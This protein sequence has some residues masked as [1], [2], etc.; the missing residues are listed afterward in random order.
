MVVRAR[1][2][3]SRGWIK[4]ALLACGFAA[5]ALAVVGVVVGVPSRSSSKPPPTVTGCHRDSVAPR[6]A[7][8]LSFDAEPAYCEWKSIQPGSRC[9]DG[10]ISGASKAPSAAFVR[11]DSPGNVRHGKYS[12]R[13]VLNPG[14]HT[15]YSCQNESVDAIK[16]IGEGEGTESWWGWS[17]KLPVGWRGTTSFGML[18]QFTVDH[19]LWPSYGM[20]NF[21]AGLSNSLRLGLHTGLTPN[22]VGD[23]LRGAPPVAGR[24]RRPRRRLPHHRAP[25]PASSNGRT[26]GCQ[27][28]RDRSRPGRRERG[29]APGR[30]ADRPGGADAAPPCWSSGESGTGK[31][32]VARALHARQPRAPGSPFVAVNC[33]ALPETL[34]ES[35]LFGHEKGAFTGAVG[36]QDRLLEVAERRH[37]VPRRDRR[38]AAS[39]SRPS[40][41][42][43]SRSASFERVGGTQPLTASTSAWSPPPTATCEGDRG[44]HLPRGPLLPAQRHRADPAAAARAARGHPAP[45]QPLRRAARPRRPGGRVAGISPEARALPPALRLAGQRPRAGER[46]RARGGPRRRTTL[47]RPEDLPETLLEAGRRRAA[48]RGAAGFHEALNDATSDELILEAVAESGGNMTRAAERLGPPPEPPPPPDHLARAAE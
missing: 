2:V 17:W 37:A 34:L 27:V 8:T 41:C 13:V 19:V 12:A 6:A 35:E 44:G 14:D 9:V 48:G 28:R 29:P 31:E 30:R 42:A 23:G 10:A 1:R 45:G 21:D 39:R 24:R 11:D 7:L 32:L 36:A 25:L 46:H 33:A 15:S 3:V 47:I 20:L 38:A 18:F 4:R 16:G 40:C 43:C 5:L 22:P 26:G